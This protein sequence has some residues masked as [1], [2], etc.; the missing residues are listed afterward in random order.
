MKTKA[1][2]KYNKIKRAESTTLK[3]GPTIF[4]TSGIKS[5]LNRHA[6]SMMKINR[7]IWEKLDE[8]GICLVSEF[9]NPTVGRQAMVLII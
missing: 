6:K 8:F 2:T 3:Y 4:D 1:K 9:R 5:Y 7:S